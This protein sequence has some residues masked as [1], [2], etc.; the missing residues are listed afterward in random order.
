RFVEAYLQIQGMR[1]GSMLQAS[2]RIDSAFDHCRVPKLILQP[3]VENVIEHALAGRPLLMELTARV[4]ED[5]LLLTIKDNGKGMSAEQMDRLEAAW[6]IQH[7]DRREAES[8]ETQGSF[9]RAK[10]GIALRNVHQRIR[11]LHG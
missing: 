5:D 10:R 6:R 4:E 8:R 1:L 3:L 2:I 11:L 9:G 7:P